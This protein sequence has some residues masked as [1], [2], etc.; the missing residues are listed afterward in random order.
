V[1]RGQR[2]HGPSFPGLSANVDYGSDLAGRPWSWEALSRSCLMTEDVGMNPVDTTTLAQLLTLAALLAGTCEYGEIMRRR[3][4][5]RRFDR[6]Q[7]AS[8][9]LIRHRLENLTA[10]QLD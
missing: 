1:A 4:E 5:S 2:S 7:R 8:A 10:S 9:G 3:E 6:D